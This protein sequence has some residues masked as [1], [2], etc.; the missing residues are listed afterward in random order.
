M[1][2]LYNS[3]RTGLK[4]CKWWVPLDTADITSGSTRF[5]AFRNAVLSVCAIYGR[6]YASKY[7]AALRLAPHVSL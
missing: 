4:T 6:R 1:E 5:G 3:D 7:C 2:P